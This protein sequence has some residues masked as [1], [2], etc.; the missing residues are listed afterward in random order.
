M[1]SYSGCKVVIKAA[2][3][4]GVAG[5]KGGGGGANIDSSADFWHGSVD[6]THV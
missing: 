4:R 6:L 3:S 5:I 1:D 2:G